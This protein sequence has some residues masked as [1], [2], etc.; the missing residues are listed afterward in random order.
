MG[1]ISHF[2]QQMSEFLL[3]FSLG[4]LI[5]RSKGDIPSSRAWGP[6]CSDEISPLLRAYCRDEFNRSC[7]KPFANILDVALRI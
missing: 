2:L 5:A 1:L 6:D 4:C 3:N 7:I